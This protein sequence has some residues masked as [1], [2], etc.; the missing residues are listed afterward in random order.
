MS[1]FFGGDTAAIQSL[2]AGPGQDAE[3][4]VSEVGAVLTDIRQMGDLG[5][6]KWSKS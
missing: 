5:I 6:Q 3:Q 1:L 4:V 2:Y